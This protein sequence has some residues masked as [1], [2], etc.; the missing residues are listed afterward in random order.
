MLSFKRSDIGI[1]PDEMSEKHTWHQLRKDVLV[2]H[3]SHFRSFDLCSRQD[4]N[5]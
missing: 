5:S 2:A 4:G 1:S 3:H